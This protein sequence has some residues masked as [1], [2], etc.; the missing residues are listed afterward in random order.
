MNQTEV[1]AEANEPLTIKGEVQQWDLSGTGKGREYIVTNVNYGK[2][3]RMARPYLFS[4][5]TGEGEQR[6]SMKARV[7][8][9]RKAI[10][11]NKFSPTVWYAGVRPTHTIDRNKKMATI[12]ITPDS[13][14]PLLDAGHRRLALE[15]LRKEGGAT[16]R[17]VDNLPIT[18]MVSLN[19]AYTKQ[20]FINYQNVKAVDSG[21]LL[22]MKITS[23]NG[24]KKGQQPFYNVA[25]E[26]AKMLHVTDTSHLF[27]LVKFDT[28]SGGSLKFK[29]L[30]QNSKSDLGTS[31]YGSA[32][33][34]KDAGKD[35]EWMATQLLFAYETVLAEA[36][37]LLKKGC[38]LA[39]EPD[40]TVG[41]STMLIG[42]GNM[43]AYRMKLLGRDIPTEVDNQVFINAVHNT[44]DGEMVDGNFPST[45][46]RAYMANFAAELFRDLIEDEDSVVG[47]HEGIPITL[48][49]LLGT[50]AFNVSVISKPKGKRGRKPKATPPV[51][52]TA[53]AKPEEPA[54]VETETEDTDT[55]PEWVDEVEE[56][57]EEVQEDFPAEGDEEDENPFD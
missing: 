54:P 17:K 5:T 52:E 16:Q 46:K 38:I 20:D 40:G 49:L 4:A 45:R 19:P 31:L 41:G 37:E 42:L 7:R 27:R 28:Q 34:T 23:Q 39:P 12:T 21:Q 29:T 26:I 2:A 47:G 53:P 6:D 43:M 55:D 8:E 24:L 44:F 10:E 18:M 35:A 51:E 9:L 15:E 11:D 1:Q 48:C 32:M 36:P 14:L 57:D 56:D 13:L 25:L 3:R 50:S 22:T 33:I 30:A